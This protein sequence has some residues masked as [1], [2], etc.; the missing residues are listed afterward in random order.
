MSSKSTSFLLLFLNII[1][2]HGQNAPLSI[3]PEVQGLIPS[4][5]YKIEVKLASADVW[6]MP[7][8][9]L[10]ECTDEKFCN[11]T[12]MGD[13]LNNWSNSYINFE[14]EEGTAVDVKIT[15]LSGARITKA[16]VHPAQAATNCI[17]ENGEA[18]VTIVKPVL[19]TVDING[20][21]DDQDTG[22]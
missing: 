10:T 12:G 3:Y 18:I 13:F 11:T 1:F 21:M 15:K 16:V 14:M 19:F 22:L 8:T 7:F 9:F 20:Q 4:P 2:I 17:V 5:F 6:M